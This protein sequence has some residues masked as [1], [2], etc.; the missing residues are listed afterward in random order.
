MPAKGHRLVNPENGEYFEFFR[1]AA[2]THGAYSTLQ[3]LIKPGGFTP[4]MHK[5][6]LQDET[7]EPI[8]GKLTYIIEG[9]EPVTI[10]PGEKALLPRGLG[11]THF[12]GGTEPLLMYQTVSPALDFEPFVEALHRHI[13][14]GNMKKGQPPFL[15]LMV[16]MKEMEGKTC[17]A[18][19]PLGVQ[20]VLANLLTPVAKWAGYK[21][22]YNGAI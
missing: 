20:K 18:N 1:T 21:A 17:V 7:F 9:Q 5:H 16:W 15:Q 2:D 22:F 8:S 10:G 6:L 4:V 11:H 12:N 3:V 13:V 19:I 14:K